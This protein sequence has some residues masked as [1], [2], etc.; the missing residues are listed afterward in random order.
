MKRK[1]FIVVILLFFLFPNPILA[2]VQNA[3]QIPVLLY[4]GIVSKEE[5]QLYYPTNSSILDVDSFEVQMKYLADNGYH[6]V[7]V[8]EMKDFLDGKIQLPI[9]SVMIQFDDGLW[10]IY[11]YVF[12]IMQKYDLHG[13][14]SIIT[15]RTYRDY[16]EE[17]DPSRL[18]YMNEEMLLEI[19]THFDLESHTNNL[20]YIE[21][22][23]KSGF[24]ASPKAVVKADLLLSKERLSQFG[25]VTLF[26]YPYGH[27][28]EESIEILKETGFEQ[29]YTTKKGYVKSWDDP[30]QLNRITIN[31]K[32][33][34]AEFKKLVSNTVAPI[35]TDIP[36]THPNFEQ[37]L[38]LYNNRVIKGYPD[39]TFKPN[40]VINRGQS[41][42]MLVQALDIDVPDK[43]TEAPFKD[44]PL[45]YGDQ[46]L[47]RAAAALK[48]AGIFNGVNGEFKPTQ[49]L[50]R[51][52]MATVLV[53]A[54]EWVL[55]GEPVQI[56]DLDRAHT[57]HQENIQILAQKGITVIPNGYF[58]PSDP[59]KRIHLA[60]FL[61]N[62]MHLD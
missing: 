26:A 16:G 1:S 32:V 9:K 61:Y 8:A 42:K 48:D 25:N 45:N 17:W 12:P 3:T 22:P 24:V 33:D 34:F 44:M 2:E 54:Y 40:D 38:W 53:N 28:T 7:T 23:G 43:V 47:L 20:H 11:R 55:E 36:L 57:S 18:Q 50:T 46:Y 59:T 60:S 21:T 15:E 13:V 39:G 31:P 29:A 5:K 49:V 27:F 56:K 6:T 58:K 62:T 30:F 35:F 41:A 51:Q 14:A 19:S 37:S 10:D 52:Q 4:H